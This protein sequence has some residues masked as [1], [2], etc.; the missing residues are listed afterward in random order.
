MTTRCC[1]AVIA[2]V[3]TLLIG[4]G[5]A[6]LISPNREGFAPWDKLPRGRGIHYVEKYT[7]DPGIDP[8]YLAQ[9]SYD[10]DDALATVIDTFDLVRKDEDSDIVSF[11]NTMADAPRWFPLQN[12]T[13]IYS[14]P[15]GKHEQVT[16]LWVDAGRQTAI[17]E[18]TWW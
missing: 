13:E 5:D 12:V 3:A 2:L 16:N 18:R 1:T 4:C 6:P 7:H 8:L 11:A 9:I 10:D 14:S 17:I 15:I